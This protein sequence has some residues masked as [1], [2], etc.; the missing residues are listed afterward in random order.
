MNKMGAIR[1]I[2]DW[3]FEKPTGGLEVRTTLTLAGEFQHKIR[4]TGREVF[5]EEDVEELG[6]N[7]ICGYEYL[8]RKF[9]PEAQIRH[10]TTYALRSPHH[11]D[12]W[13][14]CSPEI[15]TRE[16]AYNPK[17]NSA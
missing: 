13:M 3:L 9:G 7:N 10:V 6:Q 1:N 2:L 16:Y 8:R 4:V 12:K 15:R 11:P 5:T 17:L 14:T